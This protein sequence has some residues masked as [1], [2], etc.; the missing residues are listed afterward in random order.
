[1][2]IIRTNN[3]KGFIFLEILIAV[4]LVSIVFVTLMGIGAQALTL[5]TTIKKT[6]Q[7][8]ALIKEKMEAVRAFRD[9]TTWATNGLGSLATGS[10]NPYYM[11]VTA[12]AWSVQAGTET[13]SGFSRKVHFDKVSRNPSTGAIESVYNAAN[14]D[15]DT[16]KAT[17][18]IT[19]GS[20]TYTV[21]TYFTNWQ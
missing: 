9:G 18:T 16:R 11:I 20:A 2:A 3:S 5:S 15:A 1:M 21:A 7:I 4:A 13:V 8:D 12:G 6:T 19:S 10:G 14:D 17:V